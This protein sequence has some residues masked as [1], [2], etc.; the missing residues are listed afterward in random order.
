MF[1]ALAPLV[2]ALLT[3]MNSINSVLSLKVGMLASALVIH[4]VGLV[5]VGLVCVIRR[6]P[7]PIVGI[8]P[9]LWGGG[10][11]GVGTVFTSITAFSGLGAGLAVA[12][13]LLGQLLFSVIVDALGLFGRRRYPPRA[14]TIPGIALA[15]AGI[16]LMAGRLE[17]RLGYA[18]AAL[19][20]GA[21]PV[22]SFTLNSQLAT[23]IGIWGGAL[24][25]YVTGLLTTLLVVAALRPDLGSGLGLLAATPA[26]YI[27]GGGL[28]GVVMV[29][30][31]N[32]I[33]PRLPALTSVILIFSGQALTGV[34]LD[35]LTAGR[36]EAAKLW[37][38]LLVLLGLGINALLER[39]ATR[40]HQKA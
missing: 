40:P 35:A 11:V 5:A 23:R 22:L 25:N 1:M 29:G 6:E 24:A 32:S 30:M 9:W 16:A 39:R 28:L 18:L 2:G 8:P 10:V 21:L 38:T 17:G 33:F 7:R 13:A 26:L 14:R 36:F 37:G 15:L 27:L 20:S 34:L 3:L 19:A 12:L 31:T 4:L